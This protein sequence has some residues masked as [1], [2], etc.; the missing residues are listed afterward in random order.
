MRLS[1]NILM[2]P[3]MWVP[4]I[5]FEDKSKYIEIYFDNTVFSFIKINSGTIIPGN[6]MFKTL[7]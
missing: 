5:E 1:T 3:S 6:Y 4:K 2:I 7:I